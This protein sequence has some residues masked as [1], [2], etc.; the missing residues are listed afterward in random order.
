LQG[1]LELVPCD[2]CSDSAFLIKYL[3]GR[4]VVVICQLKYEFGV[5]R[6]E[7]ALGILEI[8]NRTHYRLILVSIGVLLAEHLESELFADQV[9][10]YLP[11][12]SVARLYLRV[13]YLALVLLELW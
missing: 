1:F 5:G 6:S 10:V 9:V 8:L 4:R 11:E 3:T 13:V 12:L 2:L 7:V